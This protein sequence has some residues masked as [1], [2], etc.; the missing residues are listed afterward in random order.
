MTEM[1]RGRND[2]PKGRDR[3]ATV[4]PD[5]V[6]FSSAFTHELGSL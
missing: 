5:Q 1:R 6:W 4:N 2:D 3:V